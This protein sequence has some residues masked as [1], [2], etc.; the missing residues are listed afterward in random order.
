MHNTVLLVRK[1]I[2][3]VKKLA[4]YVRELQSN[5]KQDHI[6]GHFHK[7]A[8]FLKIGSI[9]TTFALD[10]VLGLVLLT[11]LRENSTLILGVFHYLGQSRPCALTCQYFTLTC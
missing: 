2:S 11:V 5:P 10:F 7:L 8:L 1:K 4:F 3:S 9:M 6:R